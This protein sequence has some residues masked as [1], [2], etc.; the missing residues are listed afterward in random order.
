MTSI[1]VSLGQCIPTVRNYITITSSCIV[2]QAR[3]MHM[4]PLLDLLGLIRGFISPSSLSHHHYTF[5]WLKSLFQ[6]W[7]LRACTH[8][9]T[10]THTHYRSISFQ[11]NMFHNTPGDDCNP[12]DGLD[13]GVELSIG[14]SSG[15]GRWVPLVFYSANDLNDRINNGIRLGDVTNSSLLLR[16][17]SVPVERV[18]ADTTQSIRTVRICDSEFLEAGVQFRW[19]QTTTVRF[20]LLPAIDVWTLD[21]V[22]VMVHNDTV[23]QLVLSEDFES[24]SLNKWEVA[25]IMLLLGRSWDANLYCHISLTALEWRLGGLPTTR[26]DWSDSHWHLVLIQ[27]LPD[28]KVASESR[29][30]L[31]WDQTW[32]V[33]SPR[34]KGLCRPLWKVSCSTVQVAS[35]GMCVSRAAGDLLSNWQKM[36]FTWLRI[37]VSS[38]T[39]TTQPLLR[40]PS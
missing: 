11:L 4:I 30:L 12:L 20:D 26:A 34:V 8:T 15:D 16:G 10:H 37:G 25:S 31:T 3:S 13:E 33:W 14:N 7:T 32:G 22:T 19:L 23:R 2:C 9:H 29:L 21:S 24:G 17:Y 39:I 40:P 27:P 18:T 6:D 28:L 36:C 35:V 1:D 5:L 38:P